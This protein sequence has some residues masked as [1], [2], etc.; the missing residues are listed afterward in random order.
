MG[1]ARL[2]VI[3]AQLLAA[4]APPTRPAAVIAQA[5]S[6]RQ[7]VVAATLG[8]LA[9]ECALAGLESPAL[10]MVGDVVALQAQLAWFNPA[11][12]AGLSLTA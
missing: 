9:A 3:V 6:E 1:L 11:I 2:S 5:T 10:L 8:T 4:G 7:R 12:V